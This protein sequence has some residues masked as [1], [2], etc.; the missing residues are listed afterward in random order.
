MNMYTLRAELIFDED[1]LKDFIIAVSDAVN[2]MAKPVIETKTKIKR[3]RKYFTITVIVK[4]VDGTKMKFKNRYDLDIEARLVEISKQ[5]LAQAYGQLQ[6]MGI[7]T[8]E[9]PKE[10]DVT[11]G[12]QL[13]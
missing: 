8:P 9:T 13:D 6:Q 11:I 10:K 5:E 1:L 7:P 3:R 2:G 4:F 12:F